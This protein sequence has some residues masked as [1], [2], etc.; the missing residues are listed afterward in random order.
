MTSLKNY[1]IYLKQNT[2]LTGLT[3]LLKTVDMYIQASNG[4][5][6]NMIIASA[7]YIVVD[8]KSAQ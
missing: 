6:L 8:V 3:Y 2:V 4:W 7:E 1:H 5:C